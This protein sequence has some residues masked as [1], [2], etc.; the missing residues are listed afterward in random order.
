MQTRLTRLGLGQIAEKLDAG[1][2][3]LQRL[4]PAVALRLRLLHGIV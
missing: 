4:G 3:L 2:R 1:E